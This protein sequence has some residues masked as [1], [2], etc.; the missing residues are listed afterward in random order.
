MSDQLKYAKTVNRSSDAPTWH[1]SAVGTMVLTG[2][3][4][5]IML[6]FL[7]LSCRI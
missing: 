6:L 5:G 1:K 2:V 3:K 7:T 4:N